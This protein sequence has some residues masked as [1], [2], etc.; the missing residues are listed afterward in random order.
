MANQ[1]TTN[2]PAADSSSDASGRRFD[3]LRRN[4]WLVAGCLVVLAMV[5]AEADKAESAAMQENRKRIAGM[6]RS[7]RQQLEFNFEEYR[8]LTNEQ[9]REIR[10][11]H[12]E[13]QD[14]AGLSETL[15]LW[16][17]W[18]AGLSFD[19]REAILQTTD[20]DAR[21]ILVEQ[22]VDRAES[23][24][25]PAGAPRARS[26]T[27]LPPKNRVFPYAA[28]EFNT[29]LT[30]VA[31]FLGLPERP[32]EDTLIGRV[33]HH[34]S[35]IEELLIYIRNSNDVKAAS[36]RPSDRNRLVFPADLRRKLI[37]ALPDSARRR[38]IEQQDEVEQQR[39]MAQ[40]LIAG[41]YKELDL[42]VQR[43]KPSDDMLL[44]LYLDLPEPQ[45][46]A[47]DKLPADQFSRRLDELWMERE[48]PDVAGHVQAIRRMMPNR[49]NQR[50]AFLQ[51][52]KRPILPKDR[53]PFR[54]NGTAQ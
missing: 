18:L 25:N 14:D 38:T 44:A 3:W 41:F 29:L 36:N 34:A 45:R 35:V 46:N 23:P 13:V 47:L 49:I 51:N 52:G 21:L 31:K 42:V 6:S 22:L 54:E 30:V 4:G 15:S 5:P 43:L 1:T 9:R 27:Q 53:R 50:P 17:R 28:E 19:D 11:L 7:E 20:P 48:F 12:V 40:I 2:S 10:M 39:S 32:R 8:K 33:K 26:G 16:H 37:A 24:Q